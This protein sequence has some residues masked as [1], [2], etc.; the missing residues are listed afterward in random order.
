MWRNWLDASVLET[1]ALV[2]A[3]SSPATS[4]KKQR[5]DINMS[6]NIS[7]KFE[8]KNWQC[9]VTP[10]EHGY[11]GDAVRCGHRLE[12]DFPEKT[13]EKEIEELKFSIDC[14]EERLQQQ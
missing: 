7:H 8:Y 10:S 13:L 4:T 9:E 12:H 11:W 14:Y 2:H 5:K 6:E 1:V 3:G